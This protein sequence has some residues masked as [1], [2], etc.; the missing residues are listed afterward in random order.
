MSKFGKK[1]TKE[2]FDRYYG[3]S[4]HRDVRE[5]MLKYLTHKGYCNQEKLENLDEFGFKSLIYNLKTGNFSVNAYS[6]EPFKA[7][8]MTGSSDGFEMDIMNYLPYDLDDFLK[9]LKLR[10]FLIY[11]EKRLMDAAGGGLEGPIKLFDTF[12]KG[13]S[14]AVFVEFIDS[15][16]TRY[17][18]F[19]FDIV[20]GEFVNFSLELDYVT[21]EE[22]NGS[23]IFIQE[24]GYQN[25]QFGYELLNPNWKNEDYCKHLL[26]N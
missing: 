1:P 25:I 12:K 11:H 19:T 15:G 18:G 22:I 26:K 7:Y 16:K 3:K 17:Y 24:N 6:E 20:N 10:K 8:F 14:Y 2:W 5:M 13:N 9:E 23:R 21:I 4:D